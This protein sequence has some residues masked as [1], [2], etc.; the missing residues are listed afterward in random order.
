MNLNP[1][2]IIEFGTEDS[3]HP[4]GS[5]EKM[6]LPTGAIEAEYIGTISINGDNFIVGKVTEC[7]DKSEDKE[8]KIIVRECIPNVY[9]DGSGFIFLNQQ[10]SEKCVDLESFLNTPNIINK[11]E[12]GVDINSLI[13]SSLLPLSIRNFINNTDLLLVTAIKHEVFEYKKDLL[14]YNQSSFCDLLEEMENLKKQ[15]NQ[16]NQDKE[17]ERYYRTYQD[18]IQRQA[19]FD[20]SYNKS[21]NIKDQSSELQKN[22]ENENRQNQSVQTVSQNPQMAQTLANTF[23]ALE[24]QKT[25]DTKNTVKDG[26]DKTMQLHNNENILNTVNN[27]VQEKNSAEISLDLEDFAKEEQTILNSKHFTDEQKKRMIQE[28]YQEFDS[29]VEEN[30]EHHKTR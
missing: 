28:L 18:S 7:F 20:Q 16:R 2:K 10:V 19:K 6:G 23:K 4:V 13:N 1:K 8:G 5:H 25:E 30:P 17:V 22:I 12:N 29:Y 21:S 9:S 3:L 15:L 26:Y 14:K 27:N 11:L 24:V